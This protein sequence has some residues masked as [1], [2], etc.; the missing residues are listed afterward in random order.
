MQQSRQNWRAWSAADKL[1]L[2][3]TLKARNRLTWKPLPGPQ[4]QAYECRADVIL[5]G[6]AAGGGKTDLALGKALTHHQRALILRRE[7]PQLSGIIDRANDLYGEYGVFNSGKG[8]WRCEFGGKRRIIE[9]GSVQHETD[10][11][12]YQ[13]RPHDL[14]VFDEAAN[15]LESQV[16]FIAGWNRSEDPSQRCQVLLCSNPPT[17]ATGDWLI[18]WFAAWLDPQHPNP[19]APGELRWYA[20]VEGRQIECPDCSE[21]VIVDGERVYDFDRSTFDA[22][23]IIKPQTRTFIPARVTDNPFYMESGYIAKLQALPEPLRSKMLLGDFAAGREDDAYQIIPSEWIRAAQER[24]KTRRQPVIPMTA[25]GVDVARGGQDNTI[26]SPRYGNWFAEQICY[27]GADTPDGH[28]VAAQVFNLR[29]ASTVVNLDVVGVGA[30]PYDLIHAAI[31][32]KIWGVSGAAGTDELD[33]TGIFGFANLRA[34]LWWRMREAL[35][36]VNGYDLALPPDRELFADLCAPRYKRTP[37]G[38]QVETK[39][40]IKKRIGRSPDKGDSAV[41]ALAEHRSTL[42]FGSI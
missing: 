34:L 7:Y 32:N 31:G 23:E 6:G 8:V 41:Y 1:A 14:K 39:D 33:I 3:Q 27:P 15:F 35:D 5:Y 28:V 16:E 2:L 18:D 21:F 42:A 25:L 9:F 17:D 4:T 38:I 20:A 29:D 37:R 12:K 13:G 40:E 10:K 11:L 24:W 36:P 26:H 19:A 30:S 22:V